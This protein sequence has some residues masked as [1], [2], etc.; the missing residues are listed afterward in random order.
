MITAHAQ[1]QTSQQPRRNI[2][3]STRTPGGPDRCYIT[4]TCF[5]IQIIHTFCD[6]HFLRSRAVALELE[7]SLSSSRYLTIDYIQFK[8]EAIAF[9][10]R[11]LLK[12]LREQDRK[13]STQEEGSSSD[14]EEEDN[15]GGLSPP[16]AKRSNVFRSPDKLS[17]E[18]LKRKRRSDAEAASKKSKK[19]EEKRKSTEVKT[20]GSE[21]TDGKMDHEQDGGCEEGVNKVKAS[22]PV[23]EQRNVT[24]IKVGHLLGLKYPHLL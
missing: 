8:T 11:S 15:D 19:K 18:K 20:T 14:E 16:P 9:F 21:S 10:G 17:E 6:L 13:N 3:G 12:R 22:T 4:I 23:V 5:N 24:G 2:S 7:A 1:S